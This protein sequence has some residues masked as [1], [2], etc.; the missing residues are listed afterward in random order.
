MISVSVC[1]PKSACGPRGTFESF[2]HNTTTYVKIPH[3]HPSRL[4]LNV[5][6]ECE[7][8]LI[9]QGQT[10][11]RRKV[12]GPEAIELSSIS[13]PSLP[14]QRPHTLASRFGGGL[15]SLLRHRQQET[16]V[17]SC[18]APNVEVKLPE[19]RLY[20]FTLEF[21]TLD[22]NHVLATFEF[23][24]LCEEDYTAAH[25]LHL[26]IHHA[27]DAITPATIAE[28]TEGITCLRCSQNKIVLEPLVR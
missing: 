18:P 16:S 19:H 1:D 15:S 23:H 28:R 17:T 11:I 9:S 20:Q 27:P 24:I 13:V 26:R 21:R 14:S 8:V 22:E 25:A 2:Q 5:N 12:S 4:W 6:E 7:V 10:L 3:D